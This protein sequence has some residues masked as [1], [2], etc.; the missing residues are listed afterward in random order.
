MFKVIS[1]VAFLFVTAPTA[2]AQAYG[3]ID[4][5]KQG[6]AIA[7]GVDQ[8]VDR[9]LAGLTPPAPVVKQLSGGAIDYTRYDMIARDCHGVWAM[10]PATKN[11]D[12]QMFNGYS[13]VQ[14]FETQ[15][16]CAQKQTAASELLRAQKQRVAQRVQPVQADDE[17][18][19]AGSNDDGEPTARQAGYRPPMY[20]GD[21]QLLR[22]Q[23][24]G[25]RGR[26]ITNRPAPRDAIPC[27]V[28][29]IRGMCV[30]K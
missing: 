20:E 25:P 2:M 13:D 12:A 26:V 27:S 1:I 5:V 9:R 10:N 18:E 29:G 24:L 4:P 16:F 23:S 6:Q 30:P 14:F 22:L 11:T 19:V 21:R 15:R 28:R 3:S 17:Q 7:E 8:R